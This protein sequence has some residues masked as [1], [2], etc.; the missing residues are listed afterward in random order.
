[1][2]NKVDLKAILAKH[3]TSDSNNVLAAMK[4]IW[5]TCVDECKKAAN[6]IIEPVDNSKEEN[7]VYNKHFVVSHQF[8]WWLD[9]VDADV[10]IN[11]ESIE[12]VKQMIK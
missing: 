2:N 12:Q 1:M 3:S 7:K 4:E 6:I 8:D 5:N 10:T 11:L 9:E